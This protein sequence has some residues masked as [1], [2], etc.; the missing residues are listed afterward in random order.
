MKIARKSIALVMAL[1]IAFGVFA[2][3]AS[4]VATAP[5]AHPSE[6]FLLEPGVSYATAKTVAPG[7]TVYASLEAGTTA[8]Y[9][10]NTES[11]T[12]LRFEFDASVIADV[13]LAPEGG[14]SSSIINFQGEASYDRTPIA[15]T[16]GKYYFIIITPSADCDFTFTTTTDAITDP[17]THQIKQPTVDITKSSATLYATESLDL[18]V[19]NA[20]P[21]IL[22]FYWEVKDD[23][24]TPLIDE[25]DIVKVDQHGVVTIERNSSIFNSGSITAVVYAYV[26][27]NHDVYWKTCTITAM[28][29]NLDINPY[30][31]S[32]AEHCLLLGKGGVQTIS[33]STKVSGARIIWSSKN[34]NIATV[35]PF[36]N[37]VNVIG[38]NDGSTEIYA[39]ICIKDANG[40]YTDRIGRRTIRV[41]VSGIYSAITGVEFVEKAVSLRA[42]D[43]KTLEYKIVSSPADVKPANTNVTFTSSN[44]EVATVNAAGVIEAVAPGKTTITVQTEVGEFTAK[45]EIT[46]KEPLPNWLTLILAPLEIIYN[47][48]MMLLGR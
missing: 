13:A 35:S 5:Y 4:A 20:K 33:Y 12:T 23:P 17:T 45:C 16:S 8:Y 14:N 48:F 3:S 19:F 28:P 11:A 30:F 7:E 43:S 31:D 9:K 29:A 10:F 21:T 42:G 47:F 26:Y 24:K 37:T 1:I 6:V 22:N 2:V 18:D 44:P 15:V 27:Y 34:E 38:V 25:R 46:V 36:G 41:D 40:E 32:S 39:D